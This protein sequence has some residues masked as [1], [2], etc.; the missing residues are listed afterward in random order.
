MTTDEFANQR[1]GWMVHSIGVP[2]KKVI[3]NVINPET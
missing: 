2:D 3:G 1:S